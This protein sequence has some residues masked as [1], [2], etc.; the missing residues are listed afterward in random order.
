MPCI[1]L[2]QNALNINCTMLNIV[3][4]TD[5]ELQGHSPCCLTNTLPS[6]RTFSPPRRRPVAHSRSPALPPA[7]PPSAFRLWVCLV[8]AFP[9]DAVMGYLLF[10]IYFPCP[11]HLTYLQAS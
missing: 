3:T 7:S 1:L 8:W 4:Y 9:M 5:Q 2:W 11:W 6:S 10:C